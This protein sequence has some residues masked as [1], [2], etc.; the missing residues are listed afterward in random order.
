MIFSNLPL[1]SKQ[2]FK[3]MDI[4]L[5]FSK[6]MVIVFLLTI[7]LLSCSDDDEAGDVVEPLNTITNFV[8]NNDD[9]SS[10][11]AALEITGLNRTLDGSTKFTVFA[12]N[13]AAFNSFLSE[14]EFSGLDD[15][16]ADLLREILLNHVQEGEIASDALSTGYISSMATGTASEENLSFYINVEEGVTINGI[17]E[18]TSA[19]NEVA[20][21]VIHAVDAVIGLPDITTF[22]LAD[23]TFEILVQALTREESFSFVEILQ[24]VD[25][26]TPF[27]V[28]A[29]TNDAFIDFLEEMEF[30]SL[31]NIPA[32]VLATVLSYHVVTEANVRSEDIQDES[33]VQTFE[34]G[35]FTINIG[36]N[37]TITDEN[38]RTAVIVATDVQANNGV[39]HVLDTVLL[40][41][42]E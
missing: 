42:L 29:P 25:V 2:K 37:V 22:A 35:E 15:V 18:V 31:E 26:P 39:I 28:F 40:P 3:N 41:E 20:N 32:E 19:D 21:G 30:E 14:S 34:S 7:G 38:N 12:P 8:A 11:A 13:N 9:Y 33:I 23:P 17:S 5:K 4:T 27:T 1:L 36:E 6:K 24:K 10:L 16:P